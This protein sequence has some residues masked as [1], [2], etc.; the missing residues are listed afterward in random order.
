MNKKLRHVYRNGLLIA[1]ML[2][3]FAGQ[4]FA[5]EHVASGSE[6]DREE[7]KLEFEDSDE[8]AWAVESIGKMKS[9]NVLAGYA[10]GSFRPNQAVTRVEAVVTAV[11]L[12]GLEEEAKTKP[13]SAKLQF[14][15]AASIEKNFKWA[16]GY[17]MVALE[18]GLFDTSDSVLQ[19]DKPAT[20]LWVAG[21]L[22]KALGLEKEALATM[23]VVPDFKD[24]DDIAAG[25]VGYVNLAVENGIVSGYPDGSFKPGKNVTRAEMAALLVRTGDQLLEQAGAIT[26]TG[27][28]TAIDF[29]GTSN[30]ATTVT[31]AV[32]AGNGGSEESYGTIT[33]E[34]YN[35]DS[36][37]YKIAAAL[38][39]PFQKRFIPASQ[40]LVGDAVSVTADGDVV[41]EAS[42]IDKALVDESTAGITKFELELK[43]TD[44][45]DTSIEYK[46]EKGRV[47]AEIVMKADG[48]KKKLKGDEA[49]A[50][51]GGLLE[52]SAI[53]PDMTEEEIT[54]QVLA[55]QELELDQVR[56]LKLEIKFSNGEK[57]EI[58]FENDDE[59]DDND[60]SDERSDKRTNKKS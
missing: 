3:G 24:A 27:T 34:S 2:F 21:L 16:K 30:P 51:V 20:R 35:G 44:G 55:A 58:E 49:A 60:E 14:K 9:R 32:Y 59:D 45:A 23:T 38:A 18:Q 12:M 39:V 13:V 4:S 1:V 56:E 6:E 10:D 57:I 26:V 33:V 28:I 53:T 17:I 29:N 47:S 48:K 43:S 19:P 8:A 36:F 46:N 40:L 25:S 41:V 50:V 22:V 11:R 5:A 31:D 7:L 37:T 15:D 54:G 52:A 42:F